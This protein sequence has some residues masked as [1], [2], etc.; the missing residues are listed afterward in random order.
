MFISCR[1]VKR[2]LISI[3]VTNW[4]MPKGTSGSYSKKHTLLHTSKK[5][6]DV[7]TSHLLTLLSIAY[8]FS[9]F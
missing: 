8:L 3:S 6:Q 4:L 5:I 1:N 7:I 2:S 9:L